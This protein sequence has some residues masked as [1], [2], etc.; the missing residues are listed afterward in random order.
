MG[1]RKH[2][3]TSQAVFCHHRID[4]WKLV[5][6]PGW[7]RSWL[8]NTKSMRVS[9]LLK[10][11]GL[12]RLLG[13]P[14][15]IEDAGP[16]IGQGSDRHAV[17]LALGSFAL[18]ILLGPGFLVRTLP[19][20]LVQGIAPGLDAAQPAMRLLIRPALEEHRRSPSERL[21]AARAVIAAAVIAQ[22]G[23]QTRSETRSGPWQ[24]LEEFAVGM[25]QKKAFDLLV[26]VRNLLEQ[27]F[28]LVQQRHHQ[29]CFGAR[30]HRIRLQSR[31][32]EARGE[33][34]SSLLSSGIPGLFE[35][36]RQLF[37]RRRAGRWQGGIGPQELQRRGLLQLAE[38][39]QGNRVVGF[40][41]GL[42]AA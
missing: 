7:Q 6:E 8:G 17:T 18:I 31:L 29:S 13:L 3:Q 5:L 40:E 33:L 15:S 32:L 10:D 12:I 28:E 39:V 34:V 35:Q 19:G 4:L 1:I 24:S 21:Q 14:D 26:V 22:F 30:R 27:R 37:D 11:R 25:H 9:G 38:Q 2:E 42:A 23:Q 20:K 36:G 16:H 41:T